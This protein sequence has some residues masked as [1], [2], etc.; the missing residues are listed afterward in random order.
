MSIHKMEEPGDVLVFLPGGEEVD[1]AV[2]RLQDLL[3]GSAGRS[4][5]EDMIVLPL[6]STLPH[7]LQMQVFDPSV[8]TKRKVII[9]TNIG[10]LKY[11]NRP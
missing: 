5:G 3:V 9:A 2:E 4:G 1:Q 7:S 6:Y 8:Q 10:N 11:M